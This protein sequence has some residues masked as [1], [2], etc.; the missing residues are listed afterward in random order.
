MASPKQMVLAGV[1]L[2]GIAIGAGVLGSASAQS[3]TPTTS[4]TATSTPISTPART[5]TTSPSPSGSPASSPSAGSAQN[6]GD[7]LGELESYRFETVLDAG[8]ILNVRIE[9]EYVGPDRYRATCSGSWLGNRISEEV[10][11]VSG[12]VWVRNQ[13]GDFREAEPS[14]CVVNFPERFAR[15]LDLDPSELDGGEQTTVNGVPAVEYNLEDQGTTSLSVIARLLGVDADD[16]RTLVGDV[17]VDFDAALARDGNWPVQLTFA[18]GIAAAAGQVQPGAQVTPT[19]TP[20]A[21]P[22]GTATPTAT[23][24]PTGTPSVTPTAT[25]S[26]SAGVRQGVDQAVLR[27]SWNVRDVNSDDIEI[28]PPTQQGGQASPTPTPIGTA[29]RTATPAATVTTTP[30]P[31]STP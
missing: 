30:T 10:Y 18:A 27:L 29:T 31:T 1:A 2:A 23:A 19:S 5:P 15:I 7:A 24:S 13:S 4:P 17:E 21:S 22:S 14:I 16:L 11:A 8:R 6:P 20:T 9:G 25:P 28:E 3:P 12:Q 26:T